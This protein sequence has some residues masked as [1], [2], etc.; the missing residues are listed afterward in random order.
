VAVVPAELRHK[1]WLQDCFDHLSGLGQEDKINLREQPDR[2]EWFL[3]SLQEHRD[4]VA[5]FGLTLDSLLTRVVLPDRDRSLFIEMM[6]EKLGL[7]SGGESIADH[8]PQQAV[9]KPQAHVTRL[10]EAKVKQAVLHPEREVRDIAARYSAESF[11]SDQG[12]MPLVIQAVETY[13]WRQAVSGYMLREGL[14]QTDETLL[15]ILEEL[16][17]DGDPEDEDWARYR[18]RLQDLLVHADADL[19]ARHESR[20]M[21]TD[22]IEL[23]VCEAI[24]ERIRL[25]SA[26]PDKCWTELGEWCEREKS[27][28]YI[29]DVNLNEPYRLVEAIARHGEG[30]AGRVLS[31]LQEQV[32]HFENHP[33]GWMEPLVVRLAGEMRLE[34]AIPIIVE[35]LHE[36]G[37]LLRQ[38]CERALWKI[39]TDA[40]IEEVCRNFAD[41]ERSYRLYAAAVLEKI[42][43]DLVVTKCLELLPNEDN[44][45]IRVWLGH[46]LLRRLSYDG[47]EPLRQLIA[48]G[49]LDPEMRGLRKEFLTAGTLMEVEFPEMEAWRKDTEKD[50]E[51]N[52]RFHAER[53]GG[54]AEEADEYEEDEFA[55][56][57]DEPPPPPAG[58]KVG[59]NDPC[60]CG[61]GKKFKKCCMRKQTSDSPFE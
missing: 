25:L 33:T 7:Q 3:R 42:D 10:P 54:V 57:D 31:I 52:R 4:S 61:S 20:I 41:A 12:V 37:D 27:K 47:I 55:D 36:D 19:L 24:T 1:L 13:G 26:D 48:Q 53:F 50:R 46:A 59:R 45:D 14:A 11:S 21:D 18:W 2:I 51:K 35:K 29:T 44:N 38:E 56:Y 16:G 60:P 22:G 39:G 34:S 6:Q 58:Q 40:V 23:D 30:Y 8:L 15:W 28:H 43:S 32:E 9:R 5:F 49:P 17:K